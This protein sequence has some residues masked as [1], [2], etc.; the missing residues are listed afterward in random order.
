MWYIGGSMPDGAQVGRFSSWGT[1]VP[2]GFLAKV[3]TS[4]RVQVTQ[5]R[6]NQRGHPHIKVNLKRAL[7]ENSA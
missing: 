6:L 3:L 7:M 1:V 4:Q 5:L 2:K